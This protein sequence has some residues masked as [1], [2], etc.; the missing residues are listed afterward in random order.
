M[1]LQEDL[2]A[3]HF[4][5]DWLLTKLGEQSFGLLI[6]MLAIIA[7]APPLGIPGGLL[8]LVPAV[9]MI[10]GRSAVHFPGWEVARPLPSQPLRAVLQRAIPALKFAEKLIRRRRPTPGTKAKRLV[11]LI[12]LLLAVRLVTHPLPLS[13]IL[14]AIMIALIALA[15]L[16][17]EGLVLSIGFLVGLLL[18]AADTAILW[19]LAQGFGLTDVHPSTVSS[20]HISL[21]M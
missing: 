20:F 4:T 11:G 2:P 12:V 9:Q 8:V 16:E 1:K 21:R 13:N 18:L 6:L 10:A 5:L 3:D 17:E 14:P 19:K 7:I 15:Y